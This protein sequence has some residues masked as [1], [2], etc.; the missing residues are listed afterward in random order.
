MADYNIEINKAEM[1]NVEIDKEEMGNIEI[2]GDLISRMN[3]RYPKM[4][5]G[6]K[7]LAA[8]ITSNYDTA[9]FMTAAKLGE[10][11]GV[12]ES[13]TVRF[14][15]LLGY[16]GF[17][18]FHKALEDVVKDKLHSVQRI[19]IS[20]SKMTKAQVLET[21]MMSDAE[22]IKL[23][24]DTISKSNFEEAVESIMNAKRIYVVGIRT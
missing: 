5:K 1:D 24:L 18:E 20:A 22:K 4:S 17:P 6:Q 12:S 9:V 3:E 7:K 8:Y 19:E 21:V 11:V 2:N 23:T 15:T 13:T 16:N 10:M 14:A